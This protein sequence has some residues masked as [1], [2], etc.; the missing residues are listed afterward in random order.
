MTASVRSFFSVFFLLAAL[1]LKAQDRYLQHKDFS[2]VNYDAN[3]IHFYGPQANFNRFFGKLDTLLTFKKGKV[4]ILQ[5]GGSHIQAE[6]WP[7]EVR[8][9]FLSLADSI[10]GGRGFV[11]PFK[12]AGTWNPKNFQIKYTGKWQGFR[13]SVKKHQAVWG[14]SGITAVTH[15]S[16]ATLQIGY[17]HDSITIYQFNRIRVFYEMKGNTYAIKLLSARPSATTVNKEQGYVEFLLEKETDTL[18]LEFRNTVQ[19]NGTFTFFGLDLE[20]DRPGIV[21]TSIGVNGAK[22]DSFLRNAYF[23]RQMKSIRP[24]LVIFCI[25]INDA[26]YPNFNPDRYEANYDQLVAKIRAVNPDADFLFVTNNDSYFQQ[27]YPN[28]RVLEAREVMKRL[29]KKYRGGMWDLFEV[30]G[31]L[32][33]V[34]HWERQGFAKKDKIHFTDKGYQL[35][36]DLMFAALMNEYDKYRKINGEN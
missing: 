10:N 1:L 30:M 31:G 23:D 7:D 17:R 19:G 25:G 15:D 13:N 29:A 32:G 28:K 4:R 11:F 16:V 24:D 9:N 22:T 14:V 3:K 5:M 2:F 34:Q 33:S 6:I 8:K 12:L 27:K 35:I 18:S 26:Y 36:G 20:N 21:Y